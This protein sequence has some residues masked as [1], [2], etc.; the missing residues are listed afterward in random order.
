V[1]N[2]RVH[3]VVLGPFIHSAGDIGA[4]DFCGMGAGAQD[5]HGLWDGP[6]QRSPSED[7]VGAAHPIRLATLPGPIRTFR[8]VPNP[9]PGTSSTPCLPS[10]HSGPRYLRLCT[11]AGRPSLL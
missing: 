11:V 8:Q 2:L 9:L 3:K 10:R 1:I 5:D 6:F 4:S 7:G